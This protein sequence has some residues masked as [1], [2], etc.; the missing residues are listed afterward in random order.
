[1]LRNTLAHLGG[2]GFSSIAGLIVTTVITA[3]L[4]AAAMGIFG[5]YK[6]LQNIAGVLDGGMSLTLNRVMAVGTLGQTK[7]RK[8]LRLFRTYE[9]IN[10]TVGAIFAL[11][12]M[13]ALPWV[14]EQ[15]DTARAQDFNL[16]MVAIF[17]GIALAIRFMHNLYHNALFG[18]HQ[19]FAANA[20]IG[21]FSILRSVSVLVAL[22]M[23]HGTLV[24]VFMVYAA[25]NALEVIALMWTCRARGLWRLRVLPEWRLLREYAGA[26]APVSAY[27]VIGVLF[28]QLDRVVVGHFVTLEQF[29]A[30]SLIASYAGGVTALAYAPSN[31]FFPTITQ[32]MHQGDMTGAKLAVKH[33]LQMILALAFPAS[34]WAMFYSQEIGEII[35]SNP[36]VRVMTFGLWVPLFLNCCVNAITLIPYKVL[37]A[38]NR[39]N[40]IFKSNVVILI[41]YPF[42]LYV[43]LSQGGYPNGLYALPILTMLLASQYLWRMGRIGKIQTQFIADILTS[44]LTAG[45]IFATIFAISHWL[46]MP[47]GLPWILKVL[48]AGAPLGISALAY[49]YWVIAR[50]RLKKS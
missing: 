18:A 49:V 47:T 6:V 35:L 30:Y 16:Q 40:E 36:S 38:G 25:S 31:V 20:V 33:A 8:H 1:M 27:T 15:W 39:A 5:I 50:P 45:A 4:G 41:L 12:I 24:T 19:H 10:G 9:V 3:H 14:V 13:A 37:L 7:D 44:S 43:G 2:R 29:G 46:F 23:F 17:F 42:I 48:C 21:S 22:L 26:M 34:I 11:G 28:S 32:A